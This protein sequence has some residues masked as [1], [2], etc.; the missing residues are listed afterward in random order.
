MK[1]KNKDCTSKIYDKAPMI[2]PITHLMAENN[3]MQ[4]ELTLTNQEG[5]I[6]H[7]TCYEYFI[8][9][10][11]IEKEFYDNGYFIKYKENSALD[12]EGYYRILIPDERYFLAYNMCIISPNSYKHQFLRILH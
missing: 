3:Q 6:Y 4:R 2:N 11:H 7:A 12:P 5:V 9:L 8:D 1:K 10:S